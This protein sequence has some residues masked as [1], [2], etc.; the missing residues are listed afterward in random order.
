MLAM[1]PSFSD[2]KDVAARVVNILHRRLL[3]STGGRIGR[4][5]FGMP[6]LELITTGRKSGRLR[7]TILTS[8]VQRGDE[9]VIVASYGGDERHPAWFL[10]LR[11][12]PDVEVAINGQRLPMKAR[13]ASPEER[14]ELWPQVTQKYGGYAAYQRRTDREIPLVILE[15]AG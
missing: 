4:S 14:D 6:V 9:L 1:L 5:G 8:P 2:A 15:P 12:N 13:V 11:D 7:S 3:R 10:N